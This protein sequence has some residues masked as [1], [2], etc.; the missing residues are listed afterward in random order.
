MNFNICV[1]QPSGYVHSAAFAELAELVA[2]G[3]RDLRHSATVTANHIAPNATNLII[4]VHLVPP[5][6]INVVPA[7]TIVINTEQVWSDTPSEWKDTIF[8]WSKRFETW[9][10]SERNIE[11][12]ERIGARSCK[13]LRIGYHRKLRRLT[14]RANQD[15]D[16]L[17]YGS[18]NDRRKAILRTLL[19]RGLETK[20]VFGL[21]GRDRDSLIERSKVVLNLHLYDSKIFEVVRVFYLMTNSKA[22]VSEVGPETHVEQCY[23]QG[24]R[25]VPYESLADACASLVANGDERSQLETAAFDAI[26]KLPQSELLAPLLG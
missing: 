24:I 19:E 26:T 5:H 2:F 1:V 16:V 17:F 22:V 3:L 9:D 23:L 7:S 8:R 14:K 6:L 20:A 15:I 12:L 18:I 11:K 4:G 21:Y 13:H 10:Y 25:A